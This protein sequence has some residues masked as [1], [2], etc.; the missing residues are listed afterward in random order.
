MSLEK[1]DKPKEY[2]ETA[3]ASAIERSRLSI[4][5][6]ASHLKSQG[7][8]VFI[9]EIII[10]DKIENRH[11]YTDEGDLFYLKPGSSEIGRA[12]V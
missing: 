12:H 4:N 3:F 7:F 6:V 1:S 9:P 8:E 5:V 11:K 2:L 10:R